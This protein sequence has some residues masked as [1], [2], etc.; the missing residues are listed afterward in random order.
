MLPTAGENRHDRLAARVLEL[1]D[2]AGAARRV[3]L[4]PRRRGGAGQDDADDSER[5]SRHGARDAGGRR[6]HFPSGSANA[7]TML[8]AAMATN[9]RPSTA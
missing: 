5:D 9:C 1:H 4:C 6:H 2:V 8:P 7:C 3:R